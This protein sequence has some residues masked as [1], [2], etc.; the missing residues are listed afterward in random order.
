MFQTSPP[1]PFSP[2][3]HELVAAVQNQ[4]LRPRAEVRLP[5]VASRGVARRAAAQPEPVPS[6]SGLLVAVFWLSQ[7]GPKPAG[8]EQGPRGGGAEAVMRR[9][10]T[11]GDGGERGGWVTGDGGVGGVLGVGLATQSPPAFCLRLPGPERST[12]CRER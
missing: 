11:G 5:P 4:L 10:R 7:R 1:P 3:H 9:R 8:R 2:S 6:L 12:F